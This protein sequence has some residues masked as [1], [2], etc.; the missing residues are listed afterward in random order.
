[1]PLNDG[2]KGVRRGGFVDLTAKLRLSQRLFVSS[3]PIKL[4]VAPSR[5]APAGFR[6]TAALC[7]KQCPQG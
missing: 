6:G 4:G 1:M 2:P 5:M 7:R 3:S